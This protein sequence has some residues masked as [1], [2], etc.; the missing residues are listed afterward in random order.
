VASNSAE[1][2]DAAPA[3]VPIDGRVPGHRVIHRLLAVCAVAVAVTIVAYVVTV[4]TA[5]GQLMSELILGGRMGAP[6]AARAA[7]DVLRT[8]SRAALAAGGVTVVAVALLQRREA[9]A[10]VAG[11]TLVLSNLTTQVLKGV[12]LDRA[13]LLDNL[14]YVLPNSF[15]SGHVTAAASVAVA[16]LLV[17]PPILRSPTLLV[18]SI[19][20]ALVGAS[21]MIAGWHRM[22]DA[23]GGVFVATGWGAALTAL[24]VSRRGAEPVG[25]RTAA[26]ARAG[27]Q[28]PIVVGVVVL[29]VG[30]AGYLLAVADP[31][32][33]LLHLAERGGSPALLGVG[34]LIATGA[35]FLA[36]GG[37]GLAIRDVQLDPPRR[38]AP[39][40]PREPREPAGRV[41]A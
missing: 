17:L 34:V 26:L 7:E 40:P 5:L 8:T 1:R 22:A 31:L 9:L 33:V 4:G 39:A 6:E 32:G 25:P 29:V 12:V 2:D 30:S 11:A 24:L 38:A 16:L 28:V 14:F 41:P 10:L 13:D 23:I 27:A 35:S 19:A 21:T 15:P 36:L 37:F 20:V 18:A 3:G